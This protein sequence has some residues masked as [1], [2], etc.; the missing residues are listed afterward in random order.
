MAERLIPADE[1]FVRWLLD[2]IS[3][4]QKGSISLEIEQGHLRYV[5]CHGYRLF[6]SP[7]ELYR[8]EPSS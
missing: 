1:R 2:T 6:Y 5:A 3:R 8:E 4:I 7:E